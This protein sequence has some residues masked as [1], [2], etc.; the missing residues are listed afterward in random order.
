M[1]YRID[2]KSGNKLS[3]L[4]F[5]CM[6]LPRGLNV[7]IDIDK[8]E[9]LIMS[10]ID[11][12]IN[13]FDTGYVYAGSEQALGEI[14][15]RNAGAREKVY[16]ATKL[17]HGQCKTYEDF[18]RIFNTQ[19]ERLNT[20]YIDYYLMHNLS[21][22]SDWDKIRKLGA[23]QWLS[24]KRASGR[25]KQVGFSFHG[26]Q[27]EFL[28]LLDEYDWDLCLVQHNYVNENYQAGRVGIR[29]AHEKGMSV[30][31]MEPLLGGKLATGLPKKA[32]ALL[33]DANGALTPAAWAL[34][35]LW[36]Q[37][38]PTVVLS[39]MNGMDQLDD[40]ISAAEN[41]GAG[42]MSEMETAAIARVV[43]IF[44][45]S[46]KIPCTECN[47]CMPCPQSVNIPGSFA[48][49]NLRH[50]SGFIA[51][52]S[53]YMTSTGA[54]NTERNFSG[55]NCVQCGNCEKQCPQHIEIIKSL[56]QVTKRMEPFWFRA[57][58]GLFGRIMK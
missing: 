26:V 35:W 7:K 11:R 23:E 24:E 42:M 58:M 6:R 21:N 43:E 53:S 49:Y 12:G 32:V 46:Y 39:G 4:G 27:K 10:A 20:N 54:T 52:M 17:P 44:K 45:E 18:D 55:R 50:S 19:L 33:K 15:K 22:V 30:M 51:G 40:N 36:N 56:D 13:Y 9:K 34:R 41:A 25:I 16:I 14:L 3:I 1:K 57:A 31:I 38:E 48:A 47:Y 37:D 8:S 5:G 28:A 29:K 2:P